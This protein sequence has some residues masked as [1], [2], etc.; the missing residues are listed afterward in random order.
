M[1]I[2]FVQGC[3]LTGLAGILTEGTPLPQREN[4]WDRMES[5][6]CLLAGTGPVAL[7]PGAG[8]PLLFHHLGG[9]R[10]QMGDTC[11]LFPQPGQKA[12]AIA[13][14]NPPKDMEERGD[15]HGATVREI[16]DPAISGI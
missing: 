2:L 3:R 7:Q 14:L 4:S 5:I 13:T 16:R 1:D 15:I 12:S 8:P 6:P 11:C 9:A 10:H